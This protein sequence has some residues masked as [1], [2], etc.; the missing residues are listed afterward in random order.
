M[1]CDWCNGGIAIVLMLGTPCQAWLVGPR[2]CWSN[3]S[4]Q[5][6]EMIMMIQGVGAEGVSKYHRGCQT[7]VM[8]VCRGY[9]QFV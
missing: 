3:G 1:F 6:S 5:H 4:Q 7:T 9:W 2:L 8:Y